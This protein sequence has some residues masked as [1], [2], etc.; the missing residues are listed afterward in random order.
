MLLDELYEYFGTWTKLVRSLDFS[1]TSYLVW[2]KKGYIPY[3]SQLRIE[4]ITRGKFK[5]KQ[6][7]AKPSIN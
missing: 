1:H 2:R 7:H 6:A 3:T 4:K 5:A